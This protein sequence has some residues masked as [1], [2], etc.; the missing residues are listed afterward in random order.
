MREQISEL[1]DRSFEITSKREKKKK[2]MKK[3]DDSLCELQDHGVKDHS[4][5]GSPWR[6]EKER[7]R[8]VI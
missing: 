3:S 7:G 6:R 2:G 1:K 4:Y 5:H 8:K